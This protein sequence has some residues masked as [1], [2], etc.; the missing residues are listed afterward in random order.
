[1]GDGEGVRQ[2]AFRFAGHGIE[3]KKSWTSTIGKPLG[4]NSW[5]ASD[6]PPDMSMADMDILIDGDR[7]W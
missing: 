5:L 6:S 4:I 2:R 1:M 3:N 7:R